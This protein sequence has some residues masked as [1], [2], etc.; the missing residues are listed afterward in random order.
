METIVVLLLLALL[1]FPVWTIVRILGLGTENREMA[2]RIDALEEQLRRERQSNSPASQ[3]V[4]QSPPAVPS[5]GFG[6]PTTTPGEPSAPSAPPPL[7]IAERPRAPLPRPVAPAAEPPPFTPSALVT[8][9]A[10]PSPRRLNWEQFM[11]AKLFAWIGGVAALLGVAYFLKYSFE[12]DLIP[13]AVRVLFGFVFAAGLVVTGLR[14]PRP[15]YAVLAQSLMGTGVVCLYAVVFAAHSVYALLGLPATFLAMALVTGTAFVLAVRLEARVIAVLGM[16]GG[17]LT[18]VLLPT[19]QDHPMALFGYLALLDAGLIAVALRR[20][21]AFLVP[22]A[23]GGT[24]LMQA[25]WAVAFFRPDEPGTPAAISLSFCA[26]FLLAYFAAR[27]VHADREIQA[28]LGGATDW[29]EVPQA[30]SATVAGMVLVAFGFALMFIHEPLVAARPLFLFGFVLLAD[31]VL[32]A[33]AWKDEQIPRVHLAGGIAVFALLGLW[34]GM[35]MTSAQ[36]GWALA[37]AVIYA[38]LHSAFPLLQQHRRA[39]AAPDRWSQAFPALTLIVLLAP[40]L[41]LETVSLLFWPAV[42]VIDLI[43]IALAALTGGVLGVAAVLVLTLG[44]AALWIVQVPVTHA[45]VTTLLIVIAGFAVLFFVATGFLGGRVA[46]LRGGGNSSAPFGDERAQ[47]PVLS[48]L[49]PFALLILLVLRLPSSDPSPVFSVALLLVALALGLGRVLG[50]GWLPLWPL[51]GTFALELVWHARHFA[52]ANPVLVLA[53][54]LGFYLC[55]ALYPLLFRTFRTTTGPWTVGALAGMLTFPLVHRVF[56]HAWPDTM[57]GLV[58]LGF[59]LVPV[60][61]IAVL[62]RS[63]GIPPPTHHRQLA[64]QGGAALLFITLALPLQFDR[65]WLTVGLALEGAALI[66]LY[67][68]VPHRGLPATGMTLLVV[69][70][71]RLAFNPAVLAYHPRSDTPLLNWY[72]YAYGLVIAALFTGAKL[73]HA[74]EDQLPKVRG[75]ALLNTLGTV[76]AFLL[77]NV[78]IADFF[79][80]PGS[81]VLTFDFSGHFARDM[82]YTIGWSVFALALLLAGIWKRQRP[83]RIAALVLLAVAVVKL[84]FL[85]LAR[86]EALYKIGALFGVALVATLASF[87]Y[88]RFLPGADEER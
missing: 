2:A 39:D 28:E 29:A 14:L 79:S 55:F 67:R 88:Q 53:W 85:D 15:R 7:P 45:P 4:E 25:R 86:L 36:L 63:I 42:L 26:L 69:A 18:P 23:A 76:L 5:T 35:A 64:W 62:Q 54:Y 1:V 13:P 11:G 46:S 56:S 32:L 24:A 52:L 59:A 68:R 83:A 16:L 27:R 74:P 84:F 44:A 17:F 66:W 41:K 82:S 43:A 33:V 8:P 80:P 47:L 58:A 38:V 3:P 21:W 12:H 34:I 87:A 61:S 30:Y 51:L 60:I 37:L 40:V 19:N 10:P 78:Q 70:F 81:R 20:R 65:E 22:L 6:A 73:L 77:L 75:R 72:L 31:L 49:L 71:A 57:M 9:P 48:A 50:L